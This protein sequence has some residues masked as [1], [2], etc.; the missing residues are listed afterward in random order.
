MKALPIFFAAAIVSVSLLPTAFGQGEDNPTGVTGVFNGNSDTGCSYDPYTGNA[1][2]TIPDITVAGAVGAYP[3]VWARTMNSRMVMNG[4]FG[5]GG[6]WQHSYQWSCSAPYYSGNGLIAPTSYTVH[7]PD[8]RVITFAS[9]GNVNVPYLGPLGVKDRF[10]GAANTGECY[11]LLSDGGTVHF[12]QTCAQDPNPDYVLWDFTIAAP[13]QIT[14]PYG[15]VTT[16]SYDGSNRL[17]QVTE[18]AGRWLKIYYNTNNTINHVDASYPSGPVTQSVSYTYAS[19]SFGG[20]FY[21]VLLNANY[22]DGYSAAYTY[23]MSNV[24]ATGNPLISTCQD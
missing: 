17:T 5:A 23:Q 24:S 8:G 18:P 14:D 11:L 2:R 19:R 6:G 4:S 9:Q 10:M 12:H 13:T 20:V 15:L 7:Y 21:N 22:S 1:T 3:L 16:L